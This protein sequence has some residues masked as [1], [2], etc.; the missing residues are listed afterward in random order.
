MCVCRQHTDVW[1]L[2]QL[3]SA[4]V[5]ERVSLNLANTPWDWD[6]PVL[7]VGLLVNTSAS[8]VFV[9]FMGAGVQDSIP[10]T[11]FHACMVSTLP[12]EPS[13][14]SPK[15]SLEAKVLFHAL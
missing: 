6:S 2:L 13:P 8:V 3:L 15:R 1:H 5:S 4:L 11:E 12:C 7:S 10:L 14:Q 9:F